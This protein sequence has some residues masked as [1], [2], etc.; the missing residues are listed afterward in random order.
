MYA[1]IMSQNMH[2]CSY[3]EILIYELLIEGKFWPI[4]KTDET[5]VVFT[6][7]VSHLPS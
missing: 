1:Y 6:I 2:D 7:N 4:L 3:K 5:G